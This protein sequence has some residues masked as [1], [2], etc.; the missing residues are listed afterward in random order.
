A[1]AALLAASERHARAERLEIAVAA[2]ALFQDGQGSGA[3]IVA[4]VDG[5]V[6]E[7]TREGDR[8]LVADRRLPGLDIVVGWTREPAS[9]VP[10][11]RRF[12]SAAERQPPALRELCA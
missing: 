3:D 5:G 10:L 12:T 9:T 8:L 6:V 7:V 11:L 1:V 4:A 2:N